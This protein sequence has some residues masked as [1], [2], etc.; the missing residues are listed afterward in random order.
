MARVIGAVSRNTNYEVT[1]KKPLDA[2]SL[3]KAYDD[4]LLER[5]WLNASGNSIAY[6]GM[7][8]AVANTTDTSKN[9]LYFLFDEK[10][11]TALKSPDVTL[12]SNWLK[13]GETSEVGD[14]VERLTTI[15]N[16]LADVKNRLTELEAERTH[17]YSYRNGFPTEGQQ[18]HLYIAEKEHRTW[19][20]TGGRYVHIADKFDSEDHDNNPDTPEVRVIHGGFATLA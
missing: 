5:N 1:I 6:N 16:E 11:T 2:R 8:V 10:C 7:L 9:G 19:I 20:W 3:V 14:F 17:T 4:L 13:I 18:D 15:N 12:E